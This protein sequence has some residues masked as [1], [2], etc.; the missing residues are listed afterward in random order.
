MLI[1]MRSWRG[2]VVHTYIWNL[3]FGFLHLWHVQVRPLCAVGRVRRQP[4][5]RADGGHPRGRRMGLRGAGACVC[6]LVQC[7][8]GCVGAWGVRKR[9]YV[10][11]CVSEVC[12]WMRITGPQVPGC[13]IY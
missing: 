4:H 1:A 9:P 6:L 12:S 2:R 10:G 7:A 5:A 11:L 8:K 3:E 13:A